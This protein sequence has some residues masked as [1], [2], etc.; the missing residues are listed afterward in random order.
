[1]SENFETKSRANVRWDL[2]FA[3]WLAG[4]SMMSVMFSPPV[5]R[6][7]FGE[8]HPRYTNPA[9]FAANA[10]LVGGNPNPDDVNIPPH[11]KVD[12]DTL[13]PISLSSQEGLF[14]GTDPSNCDSANGDIP[15][16]LIGGQEFVEG[17]FDSES[18][19][20]HD[21]HDEWQNK[22]THP[23]DITAYLP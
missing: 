16:H 10:C 8:Q 1:M 5:Q 9:L 15:G 18:P 17:L 13:E 6:W 2:I 3:A 11:L 19:P 23:D 7:L 22:N 12:L 21:E 14:I 4:A 20:Q